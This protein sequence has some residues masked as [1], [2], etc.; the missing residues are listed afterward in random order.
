MVGFIDI[1]WVRFLVNVFYLVA[2]ASNS[3][4]RSYA[5]TYFNRYKTVMMNEEGL[6]RKDAG[7]I[8]RFDRLIFLFKNCDLFID[9]VS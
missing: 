3:A 5:D 8:P 2:S 1:V 9:T 4:F 6:V 7:S